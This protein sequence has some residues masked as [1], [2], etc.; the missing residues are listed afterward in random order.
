MTTLEKQFGLFLSNINPDK[1]AANYAMEAHNPVREYLEKDD[2]FGQYVTG[3]FLY[4]SYKR[5]TAVGDIKD[6]DIVILTNFDTESD[7]HTPSKVLRKLKNALARYYNDPDNQEYQ[8]R[9]IRVN[10]PLPDKADCEL[11]L[12]V[13]PAVAVN[14]EKEPLMVP[15]RE[16]KEWIW[17]N[18]KGHLIHSSDLNRDNKDRYVPLVKIMKWWWKYQC[19][20]RQPKVERPK[21][22]GFWIEVLTGECIDPSMYEYADHFIAILENISKKYAGAKKVPE[23]DDPGLEG[24]KIKTNMGLEEFESFMQAVNDSLILAKQAREYSNNLTSSKLWQKVFGEE[25]FP[26]YQEEE[27][28]PR[29][30]S[31][32]LGSSFHAKSLA[33]MNWREAPR[34]IEFELQGFVWDTKYDRTEQRLYNEW[35]ILPGGKSLKFIASPGITGEYEV[36][37]QVVNTGLEAEKDNGLRGGFFP[38]KGHDSNPTNKHV[39]WET[40]KYTGK[41]WIQ[42]FIIQEGVCVA[43]SKKFYVLIKNRGY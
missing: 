2:L 35:A 38:A 32:V 18:P 37:W 15:D 30:Q 10:T 29:E 13:I 7:D 20:V 24:E 25:K 1:D 40:T 19:T 14:G 4:G 34:C 41:H 8:R 12:D 3:S 11:T 43:K 39:N 17:S 5:H 36:W 21:P 26:L 31:L 27:S 28:E 6:V 9:S 42:C 33:S 22:K 16:Q 23:L